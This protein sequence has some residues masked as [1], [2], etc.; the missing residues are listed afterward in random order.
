M[1]MWEQAPWLVVAS[2]HVL[3]RA[4]EKGAGGTSADIPW[5]AFL[6]G[7]GLA[8]A[9]GAGIV[10][11]VLQHRFSQTQKRDDARLELW[12]RSLSEFYA[13]IRTLLGEN[14]VLRDALRAEFDVPDGAE[15]H[16][17]DHL[18]E[19]KGSPSA[20]KLVQEILKVNKRIGEILEAKSG[21]DLEDSKHAATWQVHRKMLARAFDEGAGDI[22][23]ELA[24]FPKE[25][26]E[27]IMKVHGALLGNV[28]SSV[29]IEKQ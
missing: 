23:S 14:R 21:L 7:S 1:A 10:T 22:K 12:L 24:Y 15:W 4:V 6:L 16:A 9:V 11:S 17:L 27:E 8:S 28:K 29:G 3:V 2:P 25:F 5:V 13:P 19:I 18:D 26:E 20:L